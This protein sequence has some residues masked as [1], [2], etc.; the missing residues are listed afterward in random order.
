MIVIVYSYFEAINIASIPVRKKRS[1]ET[2]RNQKL[3]HVAKLVM[4]EVGFLLYF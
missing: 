2:R 1:N 4:Y 3:P